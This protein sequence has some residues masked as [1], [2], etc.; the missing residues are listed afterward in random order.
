MVS[1]G[2]IL[3]ILIEILL[4]FG[5]AI[6][7]TRRFKTSWG[8]FGVGVLTFIGSQILHIPLVSY[9][10]NPWLGSL[11][12][13]LPMGLWAVI[14]AVVLGL[15]AGLFEETARWVGY[16][17]LKAR[18]KTF[19]S[20]LT[21]GAGHGGIES[22]LIGIIILVYYVQIL[23]FTNGWGQQLGIP[24]ST[25][26]GWAPQVYSMLNAP[27]YAA[28]IGAAER[29]FAIALHL[30]LSVMVWQAFVK[31]SWGWFAAAILWHA[32][33]DAAAVLMSILGFS[34]LL[35]EGAVALTAIAN[36]VF[37]VWFGRQQLE[38]EAEGDED[39]EVVEGEAVEVV[40]APKS[41]LTAEAPAEETPQ[42]EA[43]PKAKRKPRAP[44]PDAENKEE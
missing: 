13:Q 3:T 1:L 20:A 44:K 2:Y 26:T 24:D 23:I 11:Q 28:L 5:L 22:I 32:F 21:L 14:V 10:L 42:V 34:V 37:L 38:I 39:E 40:D 41:E 29:V 27:W 43:K 35:V 33:V 15:A 36:V 7:F 9:V 19:G 12:P 4:P 17:L 6:W 25:L 8:L 30:S 31:R 16:R 18:A